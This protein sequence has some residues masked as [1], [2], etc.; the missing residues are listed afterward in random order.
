MIFKRGTL[1]VLFVG[2]GMG[3]LILDSKTALK[4]ASEGINVCLYTVIPSLFPFIFLSVLLTES[5]LGQRIVPLR[6]LCK[7]CGIPEGAESLLAAGLLG[8]YPVGAQCIFQAYKLGHLPK[9]DAQRMLG[10]CNNAG[11]AFIFGMIGSMFPSIKYAW[12][13]WGIHILSSIL[14]GILLPLKS[15]SSL[16]PLSTHKLSFSSTLTKTIYV[17]ANICGWVIIFRIIISFCSRWFLWILPPTLQTAFIGFLELANGCCNLTNIDSVHTRF[18][19]CSGFLGLGG[20]CVAMQTVSVTSELGTGWYFPGKLL[21]CG[22]SIVLGIITI[23]L[24]HPGKINTFLILFMLILSALILMSVL[25]FTKKNKKTVA[26][27]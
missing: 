3:M 23:N 10:F 9:R 15:I 24:L 16:I 27:V 20:V 4:G 14:V 1:T 18:I 22:F 8:G 11:P 19:L 12:A 6:F 26:I 5:L 7:L 17:T 13:L 21:Q 2:L 25:I